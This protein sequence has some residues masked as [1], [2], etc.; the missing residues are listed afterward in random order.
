MIKL[1]YEDGFL[2][3]RKMFDTARVTSVKNK[4]NY[5]SLSYSQTHERGAESFLVRKKE[6]GYHKENLAL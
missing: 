1:I 2:F 4:F 5:R 6:T 3:I